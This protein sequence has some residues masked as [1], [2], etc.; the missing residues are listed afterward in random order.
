MP[1]KE[2][3]RRG[4]IGIG[5]TLFNNGYCVCGVDV[6]VMLVIVIKSAFFMV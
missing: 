6:Y 3:M 4:I 1:K 5:I 2:Q